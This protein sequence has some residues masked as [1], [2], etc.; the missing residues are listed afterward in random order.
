MGLELDD[1]APF[2][3]RIEVAGHTAYNYL[4][5]ARFWSDQE[6][7]QKRDPARARLRLVGVAPE[8]FNDPAGALVFIPTQVLVGGSPAWRQHYAACS[9]AGNPSP[10]FL[11]PEPQKQYYCDWGEPQ[12][13]E[14]VITAEVGE[15][16]L[17][18]VL[19]KETKAAFSLQRVPCPG[20]SEGT[21]YYWVEYE[22]SKLTC[23]RATLDA[24]PDN[25]MAAGVQLG[26]VFPLT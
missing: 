4:W 15:R 26:D 18:V 3:D 9:A 10:G 24:S 5:A 23:V 17:T 19:M 8:L 25:V 22:G 7:S 13:A 1:A 14:V 16:A 6:E 12:N 2:S 20:D 11:P 21:P